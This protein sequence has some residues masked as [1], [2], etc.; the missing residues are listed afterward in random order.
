MPSADLIGPES[1]LVLVDVLIQS[2]SL[3]F[4]SQLIEKNAIQLEV[5]GVR[6]FEMDAQSYIQPFQYKHSELILH[7]SRKTTHYPT[8]ATIV[9]FRNSP[10]LLYSHSDNR[11]HVQGLSQ[12]QD[13]EVVTFED[14]EVTDC[15]GNR[16]G[17]IYCF[18]TTSTID[19]YTIHYDLN[20]LERKRTVS[21]ILPDLK[22]FTYN[23][24]AHVFSNGKMYFTLDEPI[25]RPLLNSEIVLMDFCFSSSDSTNSTSHFR[26][27][28]LPQTSKLIKTLSQ[29]R[30]KWV[31]VSFRTYNCPQNATTVTARYPFQF[32]N[33]IGLILF[34][35]IV[36]MLALWG[37]FTIIKQKETRYAYEQERKMLR[38]AAQSCPTIPINNSAEKD[39]FSTDS[40]SKSVQVNVIQASHDSTDGQTNTKDKKTKTTTSFDGK[41]NT[42][43]PDSPVVKPFGAPVPPKRKVIEIRADSQ[44]QTKTVGSA[45]KI[46]VGPT[47]GIVNVI[48]SGEGTGVVAPKVT[49]GAKNATKDT[50]KSLETN[51]TQ[52]SKSNRKQ[53]N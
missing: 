37:V 10:V 20:M 16:T 43:S 1:I 28:S 40:K 30:P 42:A 34:S 21:T 2:F 24:C 29:F 14:V 25:P 5:N 9:E 8:F 49:V 44:D 52:E 41:T 13:S 6:Y 17:E 22:G 4:G 35:V 23:E 39:V 11:L 38:N 47:G 48:G 7:R 32:W 45:E 15:Y 3:L 31:T 33:S 51:K 50:E 12:Y 53:L 46:K 27:P 19:V 26:L 18:T 36:A